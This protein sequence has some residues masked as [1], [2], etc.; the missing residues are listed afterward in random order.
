MSRGC[1]RTGGGSKSRNSD[2]WK[3]VNCATILI[4][5]ETAPPILSSAKLGIIPMT[6][7]SMI[8]ALMAM[9]HL[10]MCVISRPMR[11]AVSI[12]DKVA[13]NIRSQ[14]HRANNQNQLR[15]RNLRG[16]DEPRDSL[17]NNR[18][19]KGDEKNSVKEGT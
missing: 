11:V 17:E 2:L 19:A 3:D 6:V 10:A 8:M 18:N 15:I 14:S 5:H 7:P 16:I 1:L 12:Q 9:T 4:R 13:N